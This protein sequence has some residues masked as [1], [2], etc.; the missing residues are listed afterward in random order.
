MGDFKSE[1]RKLSTILF[2]DIAGYTTLM[3]TDEDLAMHRLNLF[4]E[5]LEKLV[6]AHEGQIVQYFGD[7]CLLSFESATEG[8]RCAINLQTDFMQADIPIRMGIHLG[9]VVFKNDNVFGDGVNIASRIESIGQPGAILLS[10]AIR[11]QVQNKTEFDLTSLG[12]FTLKNVK[13]PVEVFA[14]SNPGFTVPKRKEVQDKINVTDKNKRRK[15]VIPVL[16]LI[17]ILTGFLT[18]FFGSRSNEIPAQTDSGFDITNTNARNPG[19][20]SIDN[21]P[22][23]NDL[24][25]D[26]EFYYFY[27]ND[28]TLTYRGDLQLSGS[29]QSNINAVFKVRAPKS[30]RV[31]EITARILDFSRGRLSGEL[32]HELYKIRGGHMLEQFDF[33][34]TDAGKFTGSGRC[35]AYCAEGTESIGISWRG[36]KSSN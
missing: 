33:T 6:P 31:E 20:E 2:A 24:V 14:I 29:N 12:S 25:G 34:F 9:D 36:S 13:D 16:F 32:S 30:R 8:V 1:T 15:L 26:W 7:A 4:K 11:D 21:A 35:V 10:R 3:Q 23:L 5:I 19:Q 18:W 22:S 27:N 28:S 17:A